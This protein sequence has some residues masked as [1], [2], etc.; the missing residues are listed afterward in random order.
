MAINMKG[1]TMAVSTKWSE[2]GVKWFA[3]V[4]PHKLGDEGRKRDGAAERLT[5]QPDEVL[6]D[7]DEV[8]GW[9]LR[10]SIEFAKDADADGRRLQGLVT[11]NSRV[12]AST[13]SQ[14]HSTYA[15]VRLS[16]TDV[17]DLCVEAVP[18]DSR[19]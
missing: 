10:R 3:Y 16:L 7:P 14:G 11:D 15:S 17:V 8:A 4:E 9:I 6:R 12:N 13:A 19:P 1:P 18:A 5:R 2:Q